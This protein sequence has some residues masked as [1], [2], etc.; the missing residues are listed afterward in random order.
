[1]K[2]ILLQELKGKGGEGDVIDVAPGFANNYLL[3]PRATPS[4]RRRAT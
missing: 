2:V 3:I 1:M 4:W